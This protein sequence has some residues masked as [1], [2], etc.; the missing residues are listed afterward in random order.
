MHHTL[1]SSLTSRTL[2]FLYSWLWKTFLLPGAKRFTFSKWRKLKLLLVS[3]CFF[4]DERFFRNLF[5]LDETAQILKFSI[6]H[7]FSK[8]RTFTEKT[9][10][11]V[12][13]EHKKPWSGSSLKRLQRNLES[14]IAGFR[15]K[16]IVGKLH[17]K[18]G[19][20]T[21]VNLHIFF[22]LIRSIQ[23]FLK[24]LETPKNVYGEIH[25]F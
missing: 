4:K 1:R 8:W 13:C 24:S 3:Y 2:K 9:S 19:T 23:L 11:F 10:I 7:F 6:K 15:P 12:Q 21:D 18:L 25:V 16:R 20:Y 5:I 17:W 14:I 22:F